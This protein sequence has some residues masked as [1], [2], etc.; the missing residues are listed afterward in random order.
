MNGPLLS[1]TANRV[2]MSLLNGQSSLHVR[3]SK[4]SSAVLGNTTLETTLETT[5]IGRFE[6]RPASSLVLFKND[7]TV[8]WK[9]P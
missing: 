1:S 9:T 3:D 8:L 6:E 2:E 7:G 4:G 5:A